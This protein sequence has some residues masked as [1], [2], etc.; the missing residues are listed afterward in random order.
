MEFWLSIVLMAIFYKE[1]K[2]DF[3]GVDQ[4]NPNCVVLGDAAEQFT[5]DNMNKAFQALMSMDTPVLISM[6]K[7]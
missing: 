6:G 2:P 4:S 1:I 5:Y 7:G 3:D